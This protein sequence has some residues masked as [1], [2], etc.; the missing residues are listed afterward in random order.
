MSEE[1]NIP[2]LKELA[3]RGKEYRE[4]N[5]YTYIGE[6]LELSLGPI[7]DKH[8]IPIAGI[9]ESRFGMDDVDE[10][11]EEIEE[12]RDEEG[13]V[14][15]SKLDEDFVRLMA[16]VA[17][18]AV[19]TEAADAD[20]LSDDDLKAVLGISDDE[21]ENIGLVNGLTLEISQ[22]ALDISSDED[23]AEKFRR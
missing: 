5:E 19:D 2:R 20:G 7:E 1:T 23:S 21:S 8:L 6:E 4:Q 3:I 13:N 11:A 10:A 15:P 14:D 18:H 9:L 22:D 12:S 16:K 17:F